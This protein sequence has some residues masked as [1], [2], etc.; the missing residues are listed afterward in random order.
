M[1]NE[2]MDT[3]SPPALAPV[4]EKSA[5]GGAGSSVFWLWIWLWSWMS[6]GVFKANYDDSTFHAVFM[7]ASSGPKGSAICTFRLEDLEKTFEGKF[8]EQATSTSMWLP[9]PLASVPQPRPGTC[10]PDTRQLPD[11]VLNFIRKHPLMDG[12]VP[13]DANGPP[14]FYARDVTFTK[15]TVDEVIGTVASR[16]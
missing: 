14:P 15:L 2:S 3:A 9:V 10:V 11:T 13:H 8:K 7:T 4:S 5:S 1:M 6:F 16:A 12:N